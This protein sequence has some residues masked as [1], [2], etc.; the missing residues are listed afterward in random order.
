[1]NTFIL[2]LII[3][4]QYLNQVEFQEFD[5]QKSCENAKREIM[6]TTHSSRFE[7]I[8]VPK[9]NTLHNNY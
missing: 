7:V 6:R 9:N 8:C 1:M 4:G 5:T 3:S 2:I